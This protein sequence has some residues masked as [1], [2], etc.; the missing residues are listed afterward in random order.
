MQRIWIVSNKKVKTVTK[1]KTYQLE[2]KI[3]LLII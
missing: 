3:Y 1:Y 2:F